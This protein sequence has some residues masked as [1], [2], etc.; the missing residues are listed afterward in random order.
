MPAEAILYVNNVPALIY[1]GNIDSRCI[2]CVFCGVSY[3]V[4]YSN[5]EINRIADCRTLAEDRI[6]AEHPH[7][8]RS[9]LL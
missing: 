9:I 1:G 5:S 6:N 2:A 4:H 7:H 3:H 8:E